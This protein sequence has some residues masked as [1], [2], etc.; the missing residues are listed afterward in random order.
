[1][2]QLVC[3]VMI[4]LACAVTDVLCVL[5][6]RRLPLNVLNPADFLPVIIPYKVRYISCSRG[7]YVVTDTVTNVA[8][9]K[10]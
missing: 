7:I 6:P 9:F 8:F 10:A 4:V 3:T 2:L 1:M 5:H